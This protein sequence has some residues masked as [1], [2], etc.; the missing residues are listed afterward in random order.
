MPGDMILSSKSNPYLP[1]DQILSLFFTGMVDR[2]QGARYLFTAALS[3]L[4]ASLQDDPNSKSV[5]FLK[6]VATPLP[7]LTVAPYISDFTTISSPA[8]SVLIDLGDKLSA[9][10]TKDFNDKDNLRLN[11]EYLL[12]ENLVFKLD[13]DLDGLLQGIIEMKFKF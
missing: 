8:A 3:K 2:S 11:L 1:E 9:S 6:K 12:S 10:L 5:Q 7:G 4:G 13:R